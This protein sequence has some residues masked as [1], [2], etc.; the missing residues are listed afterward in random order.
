MPYSERTIWS[1]CDVV[2][3]AFR[4]RTSCNTTYSAP[5]AC[6]VAFTFASPTEPFMFA[7]LRLRIMK[8]TANISR[9]R[10]DTD[11][12]RHIRLQHIIQLGK[13]ICLIQKTVFNPNIGFVSNVHL[14]RFDSNGNRNKPVK[15]FNAVFRR[16]NP[17][18]LVCPCTFCN[19]VQPFCIF[20]P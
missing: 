13:S 1:I 17:F 11:F 7:E 9:K 20:M 18:R 3:F 15:F 6:S 2:P 12:P 14:S 8:K 4:I 16:S 19:R 5:S 10:M